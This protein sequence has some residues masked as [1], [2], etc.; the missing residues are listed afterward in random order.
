M[1]NYQELCLAVC[2]IARRAGHFIATERE[3]FTPDRVELKGRQNLVSYVD[4]QAEM[5]IVN[6]LLELLPHSA[7]IG[8]EGTTDSERTTA[9]DAPVWIID[10]LD[11]T[12]NFVHGLP[13]YCVSIALVEGEQTVLG[14][15]YE[16]TSD[17]CFYAWHESDAY[18]NGRKIEVSGEK[19]TE[20]SLVITG[21]AYDC[22]D[23]RDQFND[24]FDH[25]NRTTHGARRLGS[26]ATDLVYVAAGRAECFY[27][28]N[29]S[30]WDVAAGAF[31]VRRAGGTVTDFKGGS[32]YI[33]GRQIIATNKET[34]NEFFNI[35]TTR[36]PSKP[37]LSPTLIKG[38]VVLKVLLV[39]K[40][41]F[42]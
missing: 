26:A 37:L 2:E 8:E 3:S 13:P 6:E 11:G 1:N 21:L 32:D 41:M 12:T 27:Q 25:F 36:K 30:P 18:L 14:V 10:P 42:Y 33:F 38:L 23:I 28:A 31:I 5:M 40:V 20:N 15:V 39:F 24:L 7:I 9:V 29:L 19:S 35:I 16:I 34:Y 22:E 17:E 4:K